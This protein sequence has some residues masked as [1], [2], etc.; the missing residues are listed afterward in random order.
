MFAILY[1]ILT[2]TQIFGD[3]DRAGTVSS[4]VAFLIAFV[5]IGS[6]EVVDKL[7]NLLPQASLLLVIAVLLLMVLAIFGLDPSSEKFGANKTAGWIAA[8]AIIFIFLGIVDMTLGFQIPVIHQL[9]LFMVGESAVAGVSDQAISTLI[10]LLL[11]LGVPIL[12]IYLM[13]KKS[14]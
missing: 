11:V 10:G 14:S 7:N 5:V 2:K 9:A 13:T 1:G 8:L 12:I 6:T 4:V 3:N